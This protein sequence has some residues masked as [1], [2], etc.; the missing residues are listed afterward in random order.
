VI[1]LNTVNK[2]LQK[3]LNKRND[4]EMGFRKSDLI[5]NINTVITTLLRIWQLC[6][7]A[8]LTSTQKDL[9]DRNYFPCRSD[10]CVQIS[11][12]KTLQMQRTL[13]L[14]FGGGECPPDPILKV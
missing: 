2:H 1:N 3:K 9:P 10:E 5:K 11:P 7:P 4:L 8:V 12:T 13:F 14:L 6:Y